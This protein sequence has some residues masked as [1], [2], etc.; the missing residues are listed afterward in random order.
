[1]HREYVNL[2]GS[3]KPIDDAVGLEDHFPY[4]GVLE[5]RNGSTGFRKGY[6]PICRSNEPSDDDRRIVR[7][8]LTG[9]SADGRQVG[10]GLLSPE[11]Q[12]HDKNCVLTSSWDT[13]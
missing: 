7:R 4:Q 9:E 6:Q 10:T 5:F 13:S 1:M 3:D 8:V 11:E 2:V 12:P